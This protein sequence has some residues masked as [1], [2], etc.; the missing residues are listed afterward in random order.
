MAKEQSTAPRE[1]INI[2]Y[3]PDGDP[4]N[5]EVEI[6]LRMLVVGDFGCNDESSQLPLKRREKMTN[7]DRDSFG[8]TLAGAQLGLNLGVK[9]TLSGSEAMLPVKLKF[10]ALSDFEPDSIMRQL[11]D[12]QDNLGADGMPG[13]KPKSA[14]EKGQE[15]EAL[16]KLIGL[17]RALQAL[18]Q[19]LDNN[20]EFR[21]RLQDVLD[22]PEQRRAV[23]REL[24]LQ[25]G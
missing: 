22:D 24:G 15:I 14:D 7:V 16:N 2:T 10:K 1:R 9:D 18:Q 13:S 21:A 11:A 5:K 3:R 23:M 17:R 25:D 4:N 6:P 19:P 12:M 8:T 20:K